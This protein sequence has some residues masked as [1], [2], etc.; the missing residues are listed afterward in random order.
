MLQSL[1]ICDEF[2]EICEFMKPQELLILEFAYLDFILV[3]GFQLRL[4][5]VQNCML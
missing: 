4:G 5:P 2:I 1:M 3:S